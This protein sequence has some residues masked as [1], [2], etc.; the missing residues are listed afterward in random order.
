MAEGPVAPRDGAAND[1]RRQLLKGIATTPLALAVPGGVSFTLWADAM[2]D[3]VR[4]HSHYEAFL[5]YVLG[6]A[7]RRMEAAVDFGGDQRQAMLDHGV[8]DLEAHGD[9]L[10][11]VRWDALKA[12]I[13]TPAIDADTLRTKM[14]F[15]YDDMFRYTDTEGFFVA[16]T[17]DVERLLG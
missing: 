1:S 9:A 7:Y 13:L 15:A 8:F 5:V 4:A 2:T 11:A 14:R 16:I 6:P 3:Y 17:A 10:A 12:L